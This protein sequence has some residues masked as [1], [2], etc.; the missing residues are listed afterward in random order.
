MGQ[1]TLLCPTATMYNCCQRQT[2]SFLSLLIISERQSVMWQKKVRVTCQKMSMLRY[3]MLPMLLL[4]C[5]LAACSNPLLSSATPPQPG[6][7]LYALYALWDK[8]VHSWKD[9]ATTS[10][11]L[12]AEAMRSGDGQKIW[13]TSLTSLQVSASISAGST[14]ISVGSTI[15]VIASM[16]Q[17]GGQ[18]GQV[19]ALDAQSGHMLWKTTLD[20]TETW[21]PVAANGNLYMEVDDKVEALNGSSGNQL[22]SASPEA[23]YHAG[24]LVVTGNA[25][26]VEQEASFLPASQGNTYDSII[27][28]ALRLSDG[29]EIWR[30][31]VDDQLSPLVHV[32]I[33][34]DERTVYVLREGS[35]MESHGKVSG[36]VPGYTLFALNARDGS[37]LWS[38]QRQLSESEE[39]GRQ[40][41]LTLFNQVLY[42]VGVANPGINTLSAFQ[43]QDGKQLR[44][45]QTPLIINPFVPPNHI[46]GSS[47]NTGESF[48]ALRGSDGSKAWCAS[49]NQ[50][51]PALFSQGKIYL[52]AFKVTDQGSS[53]SE[54]PAQIYV[55]NESDGSLAAHYSPADVTRMQLQSMALS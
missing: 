37:S 32:S 38:N 30:R 53:S 47:L 8:P 43:R 13:Q 52:Y 18:K 54:Q 16:S 42:V 2:D 9:L 11:T 36:P 25:I 44:T 55:L 27:L 41:S 23:G 10:V 4:P 33:Q 22:W 50:A 51:G 20:G 26:Y 15:F 39:A 45:W 48:C 6:T 1:M 29:T 14:I 34:A 35:V 46:Y 24:E 40:F 3:L 12:T 31:E 28:R 5:F 21:R 7:V 17:K 19:M 49:Y